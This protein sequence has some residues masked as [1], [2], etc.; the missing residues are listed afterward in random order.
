MP[1]ILPIDASALLGYVKTS[2]PVHHTKNTTPKNLN[3]LAR[4]LSRAHIFTSLKTSN[5]TH[6]QSK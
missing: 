2:K 4:T 3:K 5:S 6:H 1:T